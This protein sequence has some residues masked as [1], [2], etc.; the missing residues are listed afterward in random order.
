MNYFEFCQPIETWYFEADEE[1]T[2]FRQIVVKAAGD[3]IISNQKHESYGFFLSDQGLDNKNSVYLEITKDTFEQI[4]S[5]LLQCNIL[6]W[7]RIKSLLVIGTEVDGVIEVFYPQG[8]IINL[9][10]L[11]AMG[12]A[13]YSECKS[14]TSPENLYPGYSVKARVKAFDEVNQWIILEGAKVS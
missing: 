11:N 10:K 5:D 9:N 8:V 13:D 14:S 7:E 4:W 3:F 6:E 12:I 1:G 2:V